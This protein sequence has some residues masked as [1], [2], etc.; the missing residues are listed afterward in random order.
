V[1]KP[2]FSAAAFDSADSFRVQDRD[3]A[4]GV[5]F[6]DDRDHSDSHVE[7]LVHFLAIN[8]SVLADKSEDFRDAPAPSIN[9]RVAIFWEDT[10]DVID[11]SAS[12]DMGKAANQSMRDFCQQR[13]IVFVHAQ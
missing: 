3:R 2:R 8:L 9:D 1:K 10:W 11:Q 5:P 7:H 13:L 12:R 4:F 6:G